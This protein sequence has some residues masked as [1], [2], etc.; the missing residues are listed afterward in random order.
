MINKRVGSQTVKFD[1]PPKII[2]AFSIAGPKEGDGPLGAHFDMVLND[3]TCGKD[4]YEKAESQMM[5][6]AISKQ[7]REQTLK[8]VM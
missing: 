7:L 2:S 4:S 3:D 6:T 5:F 1:N 8:K